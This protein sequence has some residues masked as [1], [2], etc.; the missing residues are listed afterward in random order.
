MLLPAQQAEEEQ[1][2]RKRADAAAIAARKQEQ[3]RTEQASAEVDRRDLEQSRLEREI[4]RIVS[5]S[6]ELRDANFDSHYR[7]R[8]TESIDVN[9]AALAQFLAAHPE[10]VF[11]IANIDYLF[12]D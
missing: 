2:R 12:A 7:I 9:A 8:E 10:K 11:E 4:Q 6:D 1:E 3:E 5:E